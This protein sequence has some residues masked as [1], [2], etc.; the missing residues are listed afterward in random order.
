MRKITHNGITWTDIHK[1]NENQ[2]LELKKQFNLPNSVYNELVPRQTRA[3]IEEYQDF[4]YI[5]LHFPVHNK[6]KR[7]TKPAEL[8]F[9]V[10]S[11]EIVTIHSRDME[12]LDAFFEN[13][14]DHDDM[15]N[16]KFKDTG[17]LLLSILDKLIDS[18]LPMLD[19]A[20]ENIE[21]IEECIFKGMEKEML[22]EIAIVKHDIID[23]R[24]SIKPQKSVL[25]ILAKKSSRLFGNHLEYLVQE[26]VGSNLRVWNMLENLKELIESLEETNNS[27]LSYKI[28]DVIKVLTIISFITFPLSVIA[29][30]FGMNVYDNVGFTKDPNTWWVV[31]II[32]SVSA[33]IMVIY[34]KKRKWF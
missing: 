5:V 12:Y 3:K 18:A 6:E 31:L 24:R 13:C 16:D 15:K 17:H 23:F 7:K 11:S 4:L 33:L 2:A 27:L 29:G 22:T 20:Q 14:A 28:S 34:F 10:T 21:N 19:H 25:N 9:I 8:D 1:I 30:L 32:M 26:V